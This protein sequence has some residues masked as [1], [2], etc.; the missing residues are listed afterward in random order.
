RIF[1]ICTIGSPVVVIVF[2]GHASSSS[3]SAKHTLKL[4]HRDIPSVHTVDMNGWIEV[5]VIEVIGHPPYKVRIV[6]PNT[7]LIAGIQYTVSV[8]VC[9]LGCTWVGSH[10][11]QCLMSV[12]YGISF[13]IFPVVKSSQVMVTPNAR[14]RPAFCGVAVVINNWTLIL[15][16]V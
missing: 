9:S 12:K 15:T 10:A 16:Y 6:L 5:L 13:N 2:S 14:Q 8:Y 3:S 1:S 7:G 11:P 4:D